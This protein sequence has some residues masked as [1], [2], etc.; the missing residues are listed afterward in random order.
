[1]VLVAL[2]PLH[3]QALPGTRERDGLSVRLFGHVTPGHVASASK[4]SSCEAHT[5]KKSHG[6][7]AT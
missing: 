2:C 7:L 6:Q 4:L 5:R 3:S 1:L